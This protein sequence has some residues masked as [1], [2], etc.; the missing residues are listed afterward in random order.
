M[1]RPVCHIQKDGFSYVGH[2]ELLKSLSL[3]SDLVIFAFLIALPCQGVDGTEAGE[4]EEDSPGR[5][6]WGL[7]GIT[8]A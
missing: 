2:G 1:K 4:A 3:K 5:L 7:T 6:F 8:L